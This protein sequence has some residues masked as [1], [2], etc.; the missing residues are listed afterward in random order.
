MRGPHVYLGQTVILNRISDYLFQNLFKIQEGLGILTFST[1]IYDLGLITCAE[2][3]T[4]RAIYTGHE[5][6]GT[7][8]FTHYY[9]GSIDETTRTS[10]SNEPGQINVYQ[11]SH[12]FENGLALQNLMDIV[13]PQKSFIEEELT[14]INIEGR[15]RR[16]NII[17]CNMKVKNNSDIFKDLSSE[18]FRIHCNEVYFYPYTFKPFVR[19][20]FSIKLR[21]YNP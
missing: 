10:S 12:Y 11:G 3:T 14:F 16:T 1:L 15:L 18:F 20:K 17:R 6:I 7:Q 21:L 5:P 9:R 4:A 13:I 8:V 2:E 19:S